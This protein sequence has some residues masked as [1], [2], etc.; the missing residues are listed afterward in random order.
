M[1]ATTGHA[2]RASDRASGAGTVAAA[3]R[4]L[5]LRWRPERPSDVGQL[6]MFAVGLVVCATA[7]LLAH[8]DREWLTLAIISGAMAVMLAGSFFVPWQVVRREWTL[9]FPLGIF[10]AIAA[11]STGGHHLGAPYGGVLVLCFAY[12]GLTQTARVNLVLVPPAVAAYLAAQGDWSPAIVIRLIIVI[13]VWVLLSQLLCTMTARNDALTAALRVSAHTDPL[14]GLAN[15]RGLDLH[16]RGAR[17]GDTLVLFDLD[18]FKCYNDEHGHLAGD[19]L[20]RDFGLLLRAML[21]E[22]DVAARYGGEE[23]AL[24]LPATNPVQARV[25]LRRLRDTWQLLQPDVTFSTGLAAWNA[26]DAA[27][28]TIEAAD[29]ALYAAKEH[30]RNRDRVA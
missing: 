26:S 18:H 14:T 7:P 19:R 15:R 24:L 2:R 27:D 21:R 22:G 10:V 23:F 12:T 20:L 25:V 13:S 17:D 5:S 16:L 11:L 30:G 6:L 8:T 29:Q 3:R 9:A 1:G 28:V 4:R